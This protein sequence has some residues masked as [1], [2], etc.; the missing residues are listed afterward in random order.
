MRLGHFETLRPHCPVCRRN[1][2]TS[3]P[4]TLATILRRE[5]DVIVEGM[6]LCPHA[7]CQREYPII[8]GVPLLIADLRGYL[9]ENLVHVIAR[10]DLSGVIESV[11]GDCAGPGSWFDAMRQ[12]VGSYARDHYGADD[13]A[14]RDAQPPP[15]SAMRVLDAALATLGATPPLAPDEGP[16]VDLGCSVGG[17]SFALA[18][19][20]APDRLV[21]GV[22]QNLAMLRVASTALRRGVVTYARRRTGVAYERRV[23]EL[24]TAHAA[25]VDF[26]ACDAMALPFEAGTF[27]FAAALHVL[28]SVRDPRALLVEIARVLRGGAR[29]ALATPYDWSPAVTPIGH[30]IGGHSQ[31]G[32]HGG[33]GAPVLRALLTPGAHPA[34]VEGLE[35]V[36]E[37]DALPWHVRL[38]DRSTV[39]YQVHVAVA[40]RSVAP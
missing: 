2:A 1:D 17:T 11:L 24:D 34:S 15:G 36:S 16:I 14:E 8:D 30:W 18:A 29:V 28:D 22:D 12:Q 40:R 5:G 31:R 21:L 38:H 39:E 35:L 32:P 3:H 33:D 20:A 27:G 26:W 25:Q 23:I 10:D 9:A 4:L 6:L 37:I 19:R 7:A 13:P